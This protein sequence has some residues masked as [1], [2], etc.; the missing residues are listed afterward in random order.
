MA[1]EINNTHNNTDG[2]AGYELDIEAGWKAARFWMNGVLQML[3]MFE[4]SKRLRSQEIKILYISE[5]P[6]VPKDGRVTQYA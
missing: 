1:E 5:C 4:M 6:S 2:M 3:E